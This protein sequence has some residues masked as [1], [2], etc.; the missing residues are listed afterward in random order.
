[1]TDA[2]SFYRLYVSTINQFINTLEDLRLQN[3]RLASEPGLAAAAAAAAVNS[4]RSDLSTQAFTNAQG[5]IVQILFTF[6]SGAPTQKSYL[7]KM[8]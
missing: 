4:G 3:D 7:F 5:A 1:M 6:D 2:V 8:L